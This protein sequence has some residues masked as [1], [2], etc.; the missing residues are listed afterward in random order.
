MKPAWTKYYY[1]ILD[2]YY[3]EPQHIGKIKN[4]NRKHRTYEDIFDHLGK[5]EVSLNH[6]LALF[7]NIVPESV[8]NGLLKRMTDGQAKDKYV[9]ESEKTS[10]IIEK[11][12]DFTQPDFL[13]E[14][15]HSLLAIE[16]KL[17]SRSSL[18]QLMKYLFLFV[19]LKKKLKHVNRFSLVY[20]AKDEFSGI[21]EQEY[22]DKDELLEAFRNYEMPDCTAKGDINIKPYKKAILKVIEETDI[23]FVNFRRFS[24]YLDLEKKKLGR[25]ELGKGW[26]KFIEG[27]QSELKRRKLT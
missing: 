17:D 8:S 27:M 18:D 7:F 13:F 2:F 23:H 26:L 14:G 10:K 24:S 9:Y 1:D 19:L 11:L 20:L 3:W 22:K 21:W 12:N 15:K 16:V 25:S 5:M 6:Q 4:P